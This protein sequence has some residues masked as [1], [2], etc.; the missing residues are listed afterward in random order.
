MAIAVAQAR[1]IALLA[2][3][4]SGLIITEYVPSEVKLAATGYGAARK[5]QVG[6]MVR[7][8]LHFPQY[9]DLMMP[10]MPLLLAFV[11]HICF[12]LTH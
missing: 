11:M 3:A 8:L 2:L 9:S 6:V 12:A 1:G 7:H 10:P 4:Q 5:E